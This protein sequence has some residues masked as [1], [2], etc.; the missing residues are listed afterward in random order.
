MF[1][2]IF[3]LK[4]IRVI[5]IGLVAR[6]LDY[7][8]IDFNNVLQPSLKANKSTITVFFN[9]I[10]LL[11]IQCLGTYSQLVN[12]RDRVI[13][14]F[15]YGIIAIELHYYKIGPIDVWA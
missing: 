1:F 6:E 13:E 5:I 7:I 11:C 2:I 8:S 4:S 12:D 3:I 9:V 15:E 10:L 14:Q